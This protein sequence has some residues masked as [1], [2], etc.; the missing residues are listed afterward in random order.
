VLVTIFSCIQSYFL[1]WQAI[2]A[3]YPQL[4]CDFHASRIQI[5][6]E[7]YTLRH[8]HISV[9]PCLKLFWRVCYTRR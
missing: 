8:V 1:H 3:E 9:C 7:S 6:W 4:V 2:G 5:A